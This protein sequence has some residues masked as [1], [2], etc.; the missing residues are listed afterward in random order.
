MSCCDHSL[1]LPTLKKNYIPSFY[2]PCHCPYPPYDAP[3]KFFCTQTLVA[4]ANWGTRGCSLFKLN[5]L[6]NLKQDISCIFLQQTLIVYELVKD[7]LF[8]FLFW[9]YRGLGRHKSPRGEGCGASEPGLRWGGVLSWIQGGTPCTHGYV[10]SLRARD[11][12]RHIDCWK[13]VW[14]LVIRL[15]PHL[16]SGFFVT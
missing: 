16:L 5:Q 12:C 1:S 4:F 14:Y 3:I 10:P 15:P 13:M 11:P 9:I 6:Q 2:V 8:S 7:D